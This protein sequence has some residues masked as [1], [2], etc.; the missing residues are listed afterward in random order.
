VPEGVTLAITAADL[1]ASL[2]N[3]AGPEPGQLPDALSALRVPERPHLGAGAGGFGWPS[4][5]RLHQDDLDEA[6]RRV[7]SSPPGLPGPPHR[8][9]AVP[10]RRS[11]GYGFILGLPLAPVAASIEELRQRVTA[12]TQADLV[13]AARHAQMQRDKRQQR[14]SNARP[15]RLAVR[16]PDSATVEDRRRLRDKL[17]HKPVLALLRGR[18]H[19]AIA[20]Q[21]AEGSGK[22][23][24]SS[25]RE[26]LALVDQALALRRAGAGY[27]AA[28]L[29]MER[30]DIAWMLERATA[31]VA[32]AV[33]DVASRAPRLRDRIRNASAASGRR[34]EEIAGSPE[35]VAALA[36]LRRQDAALD[37]A[38]R[39]VG[40]AVATLQET[41]RTAERLVRHAGGLD[42]EPRLRTWNLRWTTAKAIEWLPPLAD[43]PAVHRHLHDLLDL[44]RVP[45]PPEMLRSANL[46]TLQMAAVVME[47]MRQREAQRRAER[48]AR[49]AE[50]AGLRASPPPGR[51]A[52]SPAAGPQR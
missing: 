34:E 47:E 49:E 9:V 5:L 26:G 12:K 16:L 45:L 15:T 50:R 52:A 40:R 31:Q 39:R 42:R 11:L 43:S 13:E 20:L 25:L 1:V 14:R 21:K 22:A 23:S 32:V 27:A 35:A 51:P 4:V 28:R 24:L 17:A 38:C 7:R 33:D 6:L 18:R 3:A 19:T 29:G 36:A 8:P 44:S 2:R 48:R 46:R 37:D 30:G 41:R 10:P